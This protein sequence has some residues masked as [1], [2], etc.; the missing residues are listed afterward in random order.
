MTGPYTP[1][2]MDAARS[3]EEPR[4]VRDVRIDGLRAEASEAVGSSASALRA[5]GERFRTAYGENLARWQQLRDELDDAEGARPIPPRLRAVTDI[6]DDASGEA[7]A[8][9]ERI[10]GL[11]A[12]VDTLGEE[13]AA[14]QTEL[15]KLEIALNTIESTAFFLERDDSSLVPDGDGL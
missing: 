1:R 13:L 4:S 6:E 3:N 12:A 8:E 15:A 2:Q 10:H 7:G 14:Q 9:D 5:I 11:R